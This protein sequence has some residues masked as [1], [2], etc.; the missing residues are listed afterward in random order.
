MKQL[1]R[2]SLKAIARSHLLHGHQAMGVD[3]VTARKK[4][5]DL[6]PALDPLE[7]KKN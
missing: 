3:T 2:T 1:T 4:L 5:R 7:S 6:E